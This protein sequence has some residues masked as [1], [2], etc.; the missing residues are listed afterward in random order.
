MTIFNLGSINVDIVYR[1]PHFAAP[2]ETL[3]AY[4][5]ITGLGGKGANIS[6]AAARAGA[7]VMHIGAVGADGLW[8]RDRLT[9]YGV[10]TRPIAQVRDQT[11]HAIIM[12]DDA[13]ENC[14]TLYTGANRKVSEMGLEAT[15]S[16]GKPGDILVMQNE[17]NAQFAAASVG[18]DQKNRVCY[19]PAPFDVDAVQVMLPVTNLLVLNEIE[20][21]QLSSALGMRLEELP[22]DDIVVTLGAK[23]ARWIQ[24]ATGQVDHFAAYQVDPID[25]TGAGDTFTGF[26][27]AG[28]DRGMPMAH[29][30][31]LASKAAAIM[32]T[33]L[34]AADVIPDMKDIEDF[35][36]S[37]KASPTRRASLDQ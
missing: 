18:F 28:L 37:Q 7:H 3:S 15:L 33:R 5:M 11:G 27:L 22:L 8:A 31:N 21:A 19:V 16:Q 35:T 13:G 26:L 34:G 20:A 17:T 24:P 36:F 25:T 1:V 12:V 14:I 9:E 6:V 29:A 10:D 32:V 30:L 2:G 23:G 4:E